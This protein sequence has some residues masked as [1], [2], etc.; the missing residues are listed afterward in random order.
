[1]RTDNGLESKNA[2]WADYCAAQ[3]IKQIFSLSHTP[4]SNRIVERTNLE[5]RRLITRLFT[6]NANTV[7]EPFLQDIV[8]AK[9]AS[10]NRSIKSP[11]VHV[12]IPERPV[13]EGESRG[14]REGRVFPGI[15]PGYPTPAV[16]RQAILEANQQRLA[17]YQDADGFRVGD[18][19]VRVQMSELF[20]NVR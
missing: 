9:N 5:V 1:L 4:T 7:W 18:D 8:L 6:H 11:P 13:A 2:V 12:Y 15:S 17:N 19:P 16:T 20:S 3:D 14:Q 10:W